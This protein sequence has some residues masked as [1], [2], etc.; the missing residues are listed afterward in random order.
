MSAWAKSKEGG[1]ANPQEL[2]RYAYG[3]NNPLKYTDPTGHDVWSITFGY[4][5]AFS[6]GPSRL[7]ISGSIGLAGDTDGNI[8]TIGTYTSSPLPD[9][10]PGFGGSATP[11]PGGA[12]GQALGEASG[13]NVSGSWNSAATIDGITGKGADVGFNAR[14]GTHGIGVSATPS[15]DQ[16][17][18]P[19]TRGV[20][21]SYA[22]G[23]GFEAHAA[24]TNTVI[25]ARENI[26]SLPGRVM[27]S[28]NR[29]LLP[30]ACANSS[31][32]Q[33]DFRKL[34]PS[35]PTLT[36]FRKT[37]GACRHERSCCSA[38]RERFDAGNW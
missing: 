25:F 2:N 11:V 38:S 26:P 33:L 22:P 9:T 12:V 20:T 30:R 32:R 29:T 15:L 7:Y 8:A 3:L 1:T 18:L 14:A 17:N 36:S 16:N 13:F 19:T 35:Q 24:H 10:V 37:F 23:G 31:C 4:S 28:I 5:V 27:G 21:I 34:L 6:L